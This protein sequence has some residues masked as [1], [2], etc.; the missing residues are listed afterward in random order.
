MPIVSQDVIF[1]HWSARAAA[2]KKILADVVAL[3]FLSP[4]YKQQQQHPVALQRAAA[5][6]T[7]ETPQSFRCLNFLYTSCVF[8]WAA[9]A[10]TPCALHSYAI[11]L[12]SEEKYDENR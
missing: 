4:R 1:T 9:T 8:L 7:A 12:F 2:P 11:V 5:T 6:A 3:F 10:A